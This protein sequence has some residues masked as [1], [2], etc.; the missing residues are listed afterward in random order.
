MLNGRFFPGGRPSALEISGGAAKP[1][2]L[3]EA[4]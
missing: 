4:R 3:A 1:I 2:Y